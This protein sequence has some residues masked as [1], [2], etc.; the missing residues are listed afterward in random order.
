MKEIIGWRDLPE[1]TPLLGRGPD[2][3]LTREQ[4][5][6]LRD[7]LTVQIGDQLQ[8]LYSRE[9]V[10]EIVNLRSMPADRCCSTLNDLRERAEAIR[11]GEFPATN[12]ETAEP[13]DNARLRTRVGD[14]LR[15]VRSRLDGEYLDAEQPFGDVPNERWARARGDIEALVNVVETLLS[16]APPASSP[17]RT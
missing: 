2:N 10:S 14:L 5:I 9:L 15:G 16:A 8:S 7:A 13:D 4:A 3:Y 12:R 6:Q 17:A 11:R 1:G